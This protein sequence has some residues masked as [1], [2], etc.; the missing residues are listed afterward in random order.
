MPV[1][2]WLRGRS[3]P[4]D[5]PDVDPTPTAA[6]LAA[7]NDKLRASLWRDVERVTRARHLAE[8]VKAYAAAKGMLEVET[9]AK[10]VLE[11]LDT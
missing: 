4:Y 8:K 7:E 10:A 1:I 5:A 2:D 3:V 9:F 11:V 6:E